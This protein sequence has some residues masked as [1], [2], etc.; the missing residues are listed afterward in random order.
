MTKVRRLRA[1]V[2]AGTRPNFVKA[3]P[4]LRAARRARIDM[5][6]VHTGQH[7]DPSLSDAMLCDLGLPAPTASLAV[8]AGSPSAQTARILLA[9]G[10]VLAELRPDVVVVVGDVT[11][12][13]AAALAAA[14]AGLP[15]AHVEAGLRS[16]DRTM[17]EERNRVLT[18]HLSDALYVSEPAGLAH[19]EREGFPRARAR[20]VGNPMVDALRAA[21]PAIDRRAPAPR[22]EVVVTL[23]RPGNVDVPA[24]LAAFC[25]AFA[26][27]AARRPV[28]F[29][30]HP[31]TRARL[32]EGGLADRL[33]AAGVELCAPL[34]YLDFLA[35][36][37]AAAVVATDSGGLP[38]EAA[39][40]GVPCLTLR[41]ATERPMTVSHGT[42]R[43]LGA[44][45]RRLPAAV[46]R[47]A[48]APR[49]ARRTSRLWDGHA[50]D[51]IAADLARRFPVPQERHTS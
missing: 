6:W 50:A 4:L 45:P 15:V 42:N 48:A 14:D 19:L 9:L 7:F 24:R 20:L 30:V 29:P 17:P 38:E 2:I 34:P 33:E 3:A 21:L 41:S 10:P 47:A 39:V 16:F 31:R 12:T 13:L 32:E 40:L 44:D 26:R 22:G 18:D 46:E 8:G 43:L 36:V 5:P 27:V 35:R 49:G 11:S 51:R 1:L 23:H 37:R 28:L 25:D